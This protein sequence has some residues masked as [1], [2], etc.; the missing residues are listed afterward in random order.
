[1]AGTNSERLLLTEGPVIILVEPQMGENIG[2][3]ARAMANFGLSELRL[4]NPRDG[5]PNEKAQAAASKADHVIEGTKVFETLEEAISDL[6][7]VYATTARERDG[8]KPVRSPVVAAQTLRARFTAGEGTGILFGRERWG[9]SNEEVA[10][11]DEIVTFPVNPAF[12]SLNIAQAVLLMSYEWMKSGME[13]LGSV[14]FQA[15]EQT[16]STKEQLHGLYDQLEEALES[17]NYFHP[18]AKKPKMIDN[19]RAVLS[20]RAFTEQEISVMRGV[21]SSLDRFSR[22][23]PRGSRAPADVKEHQEDDSSD[24]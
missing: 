24:A 22:K 1:M 13:D 2:M 7:F 21:I 20:R 19:L 18:P 14:P 17:R 15:M 6:N 16:Q 11:A 3:V 5:W 12:A 10:L 9:L 8:F 4:V 23:Y